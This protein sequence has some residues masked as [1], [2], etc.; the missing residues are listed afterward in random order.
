MGILAGGELGVFCPLLIGGVNLFPCT[1]TIYFVHMDLEKVF[2]F[3]NEVLCAPGSLCYGTGNL[4][5]SIGED[6]YGDD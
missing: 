1:V 4:D 2:G 3:L 6:I 5:S